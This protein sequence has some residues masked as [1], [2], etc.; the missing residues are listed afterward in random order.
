MN[1]EAFFASLGA[2]LLAKLSSVGASLAAGFST[3]IM[4]FTT[5]QRTILLNVKQKFNDTYNAQ[6]AAGSDTI[7]AIEN[8]A[9]AAFNEFCADEK[10]EFSA[11]AGATITLL[12][13]AAKTAASIAAPLVTT[14]LQ[15]A[16]VAALNATDTWILQAAASKL[17]ISPAVLAAGAPPKPANPSVPTSGATGV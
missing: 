7:N 10:A 3:I 8:A 17:A 5:D 6:V 13:S 14:Q 16:A 2:A 9:T 15:S 1:I 11:E 12:E 4:S